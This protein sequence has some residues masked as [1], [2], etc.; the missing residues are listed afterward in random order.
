MMRNSK[1]KVK[2]T[3]KDCNDQSDE[4]F[5]PFKPREGLGKSMEWQKSERRSELVNNLLP[6][7]DFEPSSL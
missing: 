6:H 4:I 3:P 5:S 2:S 1:D 7:L